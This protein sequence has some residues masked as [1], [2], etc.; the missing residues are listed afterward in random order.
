VDHVGWNTRL[1]DSR[2]VPTFPNARYVISRHE[3]E[4]TRDEAAQPK[5]VEFI[6]NCFQDS[7]LPI[8]E[9]GKAVFVD[10]T[11]EMLDNFTL[12]PAPGHSPG[13]QRIELRSG[14]ELAVFAGD[15]VHSAIQIPFWQWSSKACW[16]PTQSAQSRR[17]LLEFCVE[18][19]ALLIPG[20]FAAPHVARIRDDH[21]TFTANFGW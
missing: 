16:D 4:A 20:H 11:H 7:V 14:G 21:G 12:R 5:T 15:I 17:E 1:Q 13:N 2:W 6:R 10:G 18:E 8:V 9:A 3:Y 19:N